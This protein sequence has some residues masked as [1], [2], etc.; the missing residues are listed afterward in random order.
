MRDI[1]GHGHRSDLAKRVP[2]NRT[3]HEPAMTWLQYSYAGAM[4]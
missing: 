1:E 2:D 3:S 4:R